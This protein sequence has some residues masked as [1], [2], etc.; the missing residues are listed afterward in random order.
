MNFK[1]RMLL[2]FCGLCFLL[3]V[4][5]G[6]Q[7]Q[8]PK[9]R[10]ANLYLSMADSLLA[11]DTI[12]NRMVLVPVSDP[13]RCFFDYLLLKAY[14][15]EGNDTKVDSLYLLT[16]SGFGKCGRRFMQLDTDLYYAGILNGRQKFEQ[17]LP[18]LLD[19]LQQSAGEYPAT[20]CVA[21]YELA[22]NY[23]FQQD[24]S[25]AQYY[26]KKAVRRIGEEKDS[27]LL[28][29]ALNLSGLIYKKQYQ[30]DQSV[31][32]YRRALELNDRFGSNRLGRI[33]LHNI[34]SLYGEM[35][36]HDK[37]LEFGKKMF[38]YFAYAPQ[39]R[40]E[41]LNKAI[42]YS[43]LGL[44]LN[45]AGEYRAAID[46]LQKGISLLDGKLPDGLLLV[47]YS[48]MGK[49]FSLL[50][51]A[52]SASLFFRRALDFEP[53]AR[54]RM[55]VANLHYLYGSYLMSR[56]KEFR[57]AREYLEKADSFYTFHKSA[58]GVETLRMLARLE[59]GAFGNHEKAFDYMDKAFEGYQEKTKK[60]YLSRLAG[61]E[62]EFYT[63]EK[64]LQIEEISRKREMEKQQYRFRL[65]NAAVLI[66]IGVLVIFLLILL[67]R[68]RKTEFLVKELSLQS[69]INRKNHESELRLKEMHQ[70]LS[71]K[72]IGGMEDSN[73]RMA[74]ELHDGVCSRL[75]ML[76][77][78]MD[79]KKV[80][81]KD[82]IADMD[83]I[84]EE[85]RR[86]SHKL[87]MPEFEEMGL[88]L[89]LQNY[90]EGIRQM[91][92]FTIQLYIDPKIRM[93]ARDQVIQ[94]EIYRIVQ[95]GLTNILKHAAPEHVYITL[96][97]EEERIDLMI[98]DDGTGFD[99]QRCREGI[100]IRLMKER[101]ASLEGAFTIDSK[102]GHG[103]M[104]HASFRVLSGDELYSSYSAGTPKCRVISST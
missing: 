77:M 23:L 2:F 16:K 75:L 93:F 80:A 20:E 40:E 9:G 96:T 39:N 43:S 33:I 86:L 91:N 1:S 36:Q 45:N 25:E 34:A 67:L 62:T 85:V 99:L 88:S 84:R 71:E 56:K 27:V 87:A 51:K 10:F 37:A 103:T 53:G 72:Y 13:Q 28:I 104:L 11:S 48:N 7:E 6:S 89:I 26:C 22:Y 50:N 54:N 29:D 58:I 92:L 35:E 17:S 63:R 73:K 55:D 21:L 14:A 83:S 46:T 64:E 100:G 8:S 101:V 81:C 3:P 60:E 97:C 15:E 95:E 98:E 30:F 70:Q 59:A 68:K 66:V 18:I 31:K 49:A 65:W 57:Q 90:V 61:F 44:Y 52:D 32:Q 19:C 24:L 102:P 42:M 5:S 94:L 47:F 78:R 38:D 12:L 41:Q 69:E 4:Y 82:L 76:R 74:K 79:Q